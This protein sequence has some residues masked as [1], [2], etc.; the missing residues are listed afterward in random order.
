MTFYGPLPTQMILP[1][2]CLDTLNRWSLGKGAVLQQVFLPCSFIN[3][4]Q[5]GSGGHQKFDAQTIIISV[6]RVAGAQKQIPSFKSAEKGEKRK[7]LGRQVEYRGLNILNWGK[8][9]KWKIGKRKVERKK[10]N[11]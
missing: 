4:Q 5:G 1:Q 8:T 6:A 7:H 11:I 2:P 10:N 9:V 3:G